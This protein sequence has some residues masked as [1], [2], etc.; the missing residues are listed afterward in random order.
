MSDGHFDSAIDNERNI[1]APMSITFAKP[2][3]QMWNTNFVEKN[4]R[5][6]LVNIRVGNNKTL[7]S[8]ITEILIKSQGRTKKEKKNQNNYDY[9]LSIKK[10]KRTTKNVAILRYFYTHLS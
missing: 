4:F 3:Q 6:R 1:V 9:R 10:T 2:V 7:I 5:V 8:G